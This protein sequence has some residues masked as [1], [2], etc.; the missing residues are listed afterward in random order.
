MAYTNPRSAWLCLLD[1]IA[2][3]IRRFVKKLYIGSAYVDLLLTLSR[4]PVGVSGLKAIQIPTNLP[5]HTH[6]EPSLL[7]FVWFVRFKIEPFGHKNDDDKAVPKRLKRHTTAV[8][9]DKTVFC[10]RLTKQ[11]DYTIA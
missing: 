10:P 5:T 4:R 3:T 9:N 8:K 6:L 7:L 2:T 11:V 1:A